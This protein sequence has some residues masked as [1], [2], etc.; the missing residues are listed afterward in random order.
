MRKIPLWA[1]RGFSGRYPENTMAAFIAAVEIGANGIECD[2]RKTADG[3]F[4]I[5]H[6]ETVD[7]TTNG[8]GSVADMTLQE[9]IEL[10]AGIGYDVAF[11]GARVPKLSTVLSYVSRSTALITLNLE[12]KIPIRSRQDVEPVLKWIEEARLTKHVIHS[13]FDVGSLEVL[14]QISPKLRIGLLT[15]PGEDGFTTAKRIGAQ[16]IHPDYMDVTPR[17]VRRAH[18]EHF[19]VHPYTVNDQKGFAWLAECQVDAAIT[20]WPGEQ[21]LMPFDVE[22]SPVL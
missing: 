2:V 11:E 19:F 14:R 15:E 22:S 4:V 8:S 5:M 12:W 17:Y 9:L 7:R 21:W 10:D 1:H 18:Q 3:C 6:D 20:N 16:A 13:S